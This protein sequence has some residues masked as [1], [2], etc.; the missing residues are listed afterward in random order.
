[1]TEINRRELLGQA[2]SLA[3]AALAT[4]ALPNL[5]HTQATAKVAPITMVINQSPWFAGFSRLV[6]AYTTETGNK[7]EL[8]VNPYPGALEKVRNSLRAPSGQYD[9]LAID[10]NWMVEMFAGGFLTPVADLDPSFK[11]D[12]ATSTFGDTIF[13]NDELRT[14]DRAKG[15]LM[16]VPINGNVDVL[17]YRKDLYEKHGLKVPET[18]DQ[19]LENV[20]KLTDKGLYGYVHW[21]DRDSTVFE[22]V[23]YMFSFGGDIY[24]KASAGDFTVVF[25]SPANL[26]ALQFYLR[27]G[28]AGGYPNRGSISQAAMIQL[29]VAGKTAHAICVVGAWAQFDDPEKSAVVGKMDAALIPRAEGGQHASRAGHWIGTIARNVPR[30]KQLAA[31]EFL[32]WFSTY[33]HQL[34]YTRF[35]AVPVR[36][37]LAE[38]DLFKEPKYRFLKAQVENAKVARV[39][40][41]VPQAAQVTSIISLRL[42]ECALGKSKPAEALN[43]AAAEVHALIEKAGYK[44]GRLPDLQ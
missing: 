5:A 9:L 25:N 18:W 14:F 20:N 12:P 23:N 22:F 29:M 7:I 13:W 10:I 32:K 26:K 2:T 28:E 36:A 21:D 27:L 30:E 37:D 15:R 4:T 31:L 39:F 35:G 1:M 43:L 40:A 17:Y 33:Q 44:T 11:L 6:E 16:G 19:L 24:A 8:D 42:N 34:A 41:V 38:S 3:G